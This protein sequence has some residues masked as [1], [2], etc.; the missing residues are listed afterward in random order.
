MKSK[1]ALKKRGLKVWCIILCIVTSYAMIH[2]VSDEVYFQ[3]FPNIF[4]GFIE[5]YLNNHISLDYFY[6]MPLFSPSVQADPSLSS[7]AQHIM[8]TESYFP[9][10]V[11]LFLFLHHIT[12]ISPQTLVVLPL[13]VMFVPII[14]LAMVRNFTQKNND[15]DPI[16]YV[17]LGI[18]GILYL[19]T[20]KFYGSFYVAPAAFS[21]ILIIFMCIR[22]LYDNNQC[23]ACYYLVIC[24][25]MISLAHYWHTALMAVLFFITSLWVV[26]GLFYLFAAIPTIFANI[27]WRSADKIV[28]YRL[29][30]L[31]IIA[32]VL[33]LTFT[34]LWQSSYIGEFF[35]TVSL[36]DFL[37][38][39]LIK[40]FGGT[41]FPIPYAF[42]YKDLLWGKIYFISILL[43][44]FFSALTLLIPICLSILQFI[45]EKTIK[46]SNPLIFG[47]SIMFA[48]LI[49]VISYYASCSLNF[50]YVPLFFPVIGIYLFRN[51]RYNRKGKLKRIIVF[52]LILMC[53]LSLICNISLYLTNEAGATS[54]TKYENTKNSFEWLYSNMDKDKAVVTDFNIL[55]KY[56]QR[57]AKISKPSIDY[58]YINSYT[59]RIL[60]ADSDVISPRLTKNYVVIDHATMSKN[61][62]IHIPE[63]RALLIPRLE[64]INNCQ[65]Q[66]KI[67]E[68]NYISVFMFK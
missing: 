61:L 68:D 30:S 62:P 18:Y 41:P 49:H 52:S 46:I 14:Y 8:I 51:V 56:L 53:V 12:G 15:F 1:D 33:S 65:S 17:L 37:P 6:D 22:K 26:S 55:G 67:Y 59:Y 50:F 44:Y 60:V 66:D 16:F 27:G 43:I 23:R 10:F 25:C 28:F 57:E 45:R 19:S 63:S 20:T 36:F 2:H 35:R 40:L 7:T 64:Q 5:M 31:F 58:Y 4:I 11:M 48:Q 24:L 34:H 13:G 9:N 29:T 54:I 39:M 47:I 32:I 38:K 42:S 3:R 21:L